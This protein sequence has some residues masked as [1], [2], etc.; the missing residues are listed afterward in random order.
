M[1]ARGDGSCS[2]DERGQDLAGK[3]PT[4]QNRE[5]G[6]ELWGAQEQGDS[7]ASSQGAGGQEEGCRGRGGNVGGGV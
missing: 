2:K 4:E 3:A 5:R 1:T 6:E 7:G